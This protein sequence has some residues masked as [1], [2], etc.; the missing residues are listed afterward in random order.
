[1]AP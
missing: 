1:P